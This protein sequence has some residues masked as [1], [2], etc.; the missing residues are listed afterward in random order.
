[1]TTY[2]EMAVHLA[3]AADVFSGDKFCIDVLGGSGIGLCQVLR[4]F[5]HILLLI[6]RLI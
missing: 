6:Y 1:M 2:L 3:A 4:I 5:L